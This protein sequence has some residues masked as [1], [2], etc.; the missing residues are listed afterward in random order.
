MTTN[1][2]LQAA[3]D[4]AARLPWVKAIDIT[5]ASPTW[6]GSLTLRDR[7]GNETTVHLDDL[8]AG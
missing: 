1:A 5:P 3:A 6:P 7:D 4:A 2:I 8:L